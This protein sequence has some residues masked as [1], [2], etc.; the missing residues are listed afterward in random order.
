M[1]SREPSSIAYGNIRPGGFQVR[2]RTGSIQILPPLVNAFPPGQIDQF[3]EGGPP[4]AVVARQQQV[5]S[6][7]AGAGRE[8]QP[9]APLES[10][11]FHRGPGRT[12]K[13]VEYARDAFRQSRNPD[14]GGPD[15]VPVPPT[16]FRHGLHLPAEQHRADQNDRQHQQHDPVFGPVEEPSLHGSNSSLGANPPSAVDRPES[17]RRG[18]AKQG[19]DSDTDVVVASPA[20]GTCAASKA[21]VST[22]MR[23]RQRPLDLGTSVQHDQVSRSWS[24][25]SREPSSIAHGN[26]RLGSSRSASAPRVRPWRR[27]DPRRSRGLR[28]D[29]LPAVPRARR[30][31]AEP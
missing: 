7:L 3:D 27:P 20:S 24:M 15:P 9:R 25:N 16:T 11:F 26:I 23:R 14:G 2:E 19:A 8:H 21:V 6:I 30:P 31:R 13:K 17:V 28:A 1:N 29:T 12:Q 4:V 10:L 22:G 5:S 18:L